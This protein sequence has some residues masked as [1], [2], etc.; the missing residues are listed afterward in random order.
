MTR[1]TN[2]SGNFV[3]MVTPFRENGAFD[4][5]SVRQLVDTFASEGADG[6]VV[7]GSTGEYFSMTD[8]ER[9]TL[10]RVV[11][12]Q[13]KGR[14]RLVA[15]ATEISTRRAVA[16][17]AAAKEA[18]YDGALVLPPPYV[19]PTTK[20]VIGHFSAI[21]EVGLPVMVYNNPGRTGVNL[22]QVYLEKL[23]H[24]KSFVALKDSVKDLGQASAT[25]RRFR[26]E[27]AIFPGLES[28]YIPSHQRGGAGIV[29]MAP[30]VLGADAISLSKL[31][32]EGD[33]AKAAQVQERI[34][35][36]YARMYAGDYNPYVVLKEAM[37]ILGRAGGWTRDPLL[38][39]TDPDRDAL[40]GLL[41]EIVV[42]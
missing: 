6:L 29:S 40:K 30:N 7:A 24:L 5:A 35:R 39:M 18:G 13:S 10:F 2:W 36:L 8:E 27:I 11:A 38:A 21:D 34:D 26:N 41:S 28:Y 22:D 12:D 15:G 33:Y 3:V 19:L 4:E 9:V 42:K 25:L 14:V 1:R 37:R 17:T 32:A 23:L 31:V 16:L 20:E